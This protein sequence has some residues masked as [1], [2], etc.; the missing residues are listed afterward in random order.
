[1]LIAEV[2]CF[3]SAG[4]AFFQCFLAFGAGDGSV[5]KKEVNVYFDILDSHFD[6]FCLLHILFFSNSLIMYDSLLIRTRI[7]HRNHMI[8]KRR[9]TAW[10][11]LCCMSAS[12]CSMR[13]TFSPDPRH[14]G[15][16]GDNTFAWR[17]SE[18]KR[19]PAP[20]A[21][22]RCITL[23][24]SHARFVLKSNNRQRTSLMT[25][26]FIRIDP[27]GHE[28]NK[29]LDDWSSD[30]WMTDITNRIWGGIVPNFYDGIWGITL[31]I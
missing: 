26:I 30:A 16:P 2:P 8:S 10:I 9:S 6:T 23:C 28:E 3:G 27:W 1:M 7:L 22:V 17:A 12:T 4:S 19:P 13:P 20:R 5:W 29:G 25:R 21:S 14:P 24:N 31:K 15:H 11:S 18:P